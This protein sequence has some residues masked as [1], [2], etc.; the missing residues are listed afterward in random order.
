MSLN[1]LYSNW[2]KYAIDVDYTNNSERIRGRLPLTKAYIY[3]YWS[4]DEEWIIFYSWNMGTPLSVMKCN[5]KG[6]CYVKN[7]RELWI[8][9]GTIAQ[10]GK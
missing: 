9:I 5:S 2:K 3:C 8:K 6:D 4:E 1:E 7:P 10:I